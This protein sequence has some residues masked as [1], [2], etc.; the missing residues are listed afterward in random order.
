MLNCSHS[1]RVTDVQTIRHGSD[2]GSDNQ[3]NTLLSNVIGPTPLRL[4][5]HFYKSY[6]RRIS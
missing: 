6:I 2:K 1:V 5:T 3:D 4:I